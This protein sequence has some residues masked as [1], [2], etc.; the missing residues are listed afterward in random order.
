[1]FQQSQQNF[2]QFAKCP[3]ISN[4]DPAKFPNMNSLVNANVIFLKYNCLSSLKEINISQKHS[5]KISLS[6][7]LKRR[8]CHL[9][10]A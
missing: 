2:K 6:Y 8:Q 4:M 1:M 10:N 7:T 9:F 5:F 3:Q